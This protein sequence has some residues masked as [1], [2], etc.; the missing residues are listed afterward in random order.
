MGGYCWPN[1]GSWYLFFVLDACRRYGLDLEDW[2]CIG[3]N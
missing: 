1:V 3:L 2:H